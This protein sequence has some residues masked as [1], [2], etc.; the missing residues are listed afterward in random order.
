MQEPVGRS[1]QKG[2]GLRALT[3]KDAAGQK[4]LFRAE[5]SGKNIS[6]CGQSGFERAIFHSGKKEIP[7]NA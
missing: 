2:C 4:E 7:G 5:Q 6:F 3:H 1:R